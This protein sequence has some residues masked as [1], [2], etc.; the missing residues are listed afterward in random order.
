MAAE[1]AAAEGGSAAMETD[2][3][4]SEPP[5]SPVLSPEPGSGQIKFRVVFKSVVH[6]VVFGLDQT[7]GELKAHLE[8]KTGC[9]ASVQ[10]LSFKGPV[11]D[12]SQTLKERKFTPKCK[13]L[14]IGPTA[15]DLLQQASMAGPVVESDPLPGA[16][17]REPTVAWCEQAI[18]RK[19]L[20]KGIPPD[21][22]MGYMPLDGPEPV[23]T[24]PLVLFDYSGKIRLSFKMAEQMLVIGTKE[25][26]RQV[27]LS[28]IYD[29][30]SEPI[31]EHPA[32]HIMAMQLGPTEKSIKF[33]YWV[34]AQYVKSIINLFGK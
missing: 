32:Y 14:L 12:D 34:P 18:H 19:V 15:E 21:V 16:V 10:K 2:P 20:D 26:T 6:E 9:P 1:Q 11:K 5:V 17:V 8:G 33:F 13:V 23:P 28:S 31:A 7:I 29:C 4:G 25:R 3:T 22:E 27:P 24:V 30:K